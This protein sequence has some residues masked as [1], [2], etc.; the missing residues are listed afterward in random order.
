MQVLLAPVGRDPQDGRP[1]AEGTPERARLTAQVPAGL[2]DVERG[3]I[4]CPLEQLVVDRLERLG[5]ASEDRVD[6]PDRERAAEQLLHQL[7]QLPAR[8]TIPNRERRDRR[9]QLR[10]EAAARDTRRQLSS[11]RAAARWAAE[12]LQAVL[13]DLDRE[14][15]QLRDLMPRRCR[16][17]LTL[18]VGENVAAATPLRPVIDDI[19]H[20][21]DWKQRSPVTRMSRLSARLAP[22]PARAAALPEPRRVM[23]RRERGVARVALQPLLELLDPLRQRSQLRVLRLQPR[24]QR[25]QRLDHRLASR[26]VDRLRL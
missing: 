4:T 3:G 11:N 10:T 5:R 23:A 20:P 8:K 9:L 15:R 21:L 2:V 6:R 14:R 22:R 19:R 13:A 12:P 25:H 17:G 7:D 1:L 16:N 26:R 18:V 24:R